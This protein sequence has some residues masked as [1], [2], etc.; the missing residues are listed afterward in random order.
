MS[1][2]TLAVREQRLVYSKC[3][4]KL[5]WTKNSLSGRII[6]QKWER[7]TFPNKQKKKRNSIASTL[8]YSNAEK[9]MAQAEKEM[10]GSKKWLFLHEN[11]KGTWSDNHVD[12]QAIAQCAFS[13]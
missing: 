6:L 12:K 10:M 1:L 2:E 7:N 4:K 11:M 9:R 5:V 13:L 3:W 8:F